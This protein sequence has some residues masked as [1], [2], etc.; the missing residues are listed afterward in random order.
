[1]I[2]LTGGSG[3]LGAEIRKLIS[4][5]YAPT[6]KEFDILNPKFI[7]SVDLIVHTA[8]YTQV[9]RAEINRNECYRLNV[10]GTRNLSRL[11]IPMLYIST[12]SV[13]GGETGNYNENDIP[14]PKNF[15]SLTKFLGEQQ[16]DDYSVII[17]TAF[18][19]RPWRYEYAS[20]DRYSSADY[21]DNM[22]V[23]IV[24]A[25]RLFDK[26]PKVVHIGAD[27]KSHYEL[28]KISRPDIKPIS[29]ES[30]PVP[31]PVDTSL[32]SSLWRTLSK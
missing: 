24:K 19:K 2:L 16:L 7:P 30:I 8:A 1:M 31:R 17:R 10:E 26:L 12:D 14:Y 32:D 4:D 22:A 5:I 28:A 9:D 20:T 23:E 21:V 25:I 11:G 3:L 29:N 13:F 15:Y 18:R 6:H 27:R